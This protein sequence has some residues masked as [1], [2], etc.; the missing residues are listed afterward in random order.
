MAYSVSGSAEAVLLAEQVGGFCICGNHLLGVL[1]DDA[2]G[3]R[4]LWPVGT[5]FQ[6]LDALHEAVARS[7][8]VTAPG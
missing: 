5:S 3:T 1:C 4:Y 7:L 8:G 6:C 2:V